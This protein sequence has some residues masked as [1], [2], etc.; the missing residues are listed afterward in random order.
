MAN[1]V[2]IVYVVFFT[3]FL[4]SGVLFAQEEMTSELDSINSYDPSLYQIRKFYQ[5]YNFYGSPVFYNMGGSFMHNDVIWFPHIGLRLDTEDGMVPYGNLGLEVKK[6]SFL[7]VFS[8]IFQITPPLLDIKSIGEFNYMSMFSEITLGY[9]NDGVNI[10]SV[11]QVGAIMMYRID[12]QDQVNPLGIR[13]EF[14][15]E[16]PFLDNGIHRIAM[17]LNTYFYIFPMEKHYSFRVSIDLPFSFLWS[18]GILETLF[19]A[20]IEYSDFFYNSKEIFVIDRVPKAQRIRRGLAPQYR[21]YQLSGSLEI[22]QRIYFKGLS[23]AA[24]RTYISV[25]STIGYG[26]PRNTIMSRGRLFLLYG[27]G[28]GYNIKDTFPLQLQVGTDLDLNVF[29]NIT[30]A[31][32]IM[33]PT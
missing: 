6:G 4:S 18:R 26:V 11:T 10:Y 3:L 30:F 32:A 14:R 23:P 31:S 27:G 25:F 19:L 16:T 24:S 22:E 5:T 9:I 33:F 8:A 13:Q 17:I 2:K 21:A 12:N 20:Q 29:V 15:L 28:I 7:G 1:I